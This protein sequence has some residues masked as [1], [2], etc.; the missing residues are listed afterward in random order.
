MYRN[1]LKNGCSGKEENCQK[2]LLFFFDSS[3]SNHCEIYF[4][5]DYGV[6]RVDYLTY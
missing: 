1:N 5:F 4:I 2:L 3:L 6:S